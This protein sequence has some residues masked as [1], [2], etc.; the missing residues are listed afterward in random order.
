MLD[1]GVQSSSETASE[2]LND[3]FC[4]D[5]ASQVIIQTIHNLTLAHHQLFLQRT[6]IQFHPKFTLGLQPNGA[7]LALNHLAETSVPSVDRIH[8]VQPVL[9]PVG[10]YK[11]LNRGFQWFGFIALHRP[12][13]HL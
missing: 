12:N 11:L 6:T 8:L 10:L 4:Y 13:L 3:D 9:H 2:S 1:W 7:G 5:P